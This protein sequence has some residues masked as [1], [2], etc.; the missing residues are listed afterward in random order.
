MII[1]TCGNINSMIMVV[2][3]IFLFD[4]AYARK[5]VK[6]RNKCVWLVY[7]YCKKEIRHTTKG[8]YAQ[9]V[10]NGLGP[11]VCSTTIVEGVI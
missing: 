5:A 3:H 7:E 4:S 8:S 2:N 6:A 10:E 11:Y 1:T 9:Y